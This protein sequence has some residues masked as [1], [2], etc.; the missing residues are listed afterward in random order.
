[1]HP[2]EIPLCRAVDQLIELAIAEDIGHGDITT[3][4]LGLGLA[5]GQARIVANEPLVIAG[6]DAVRRVYEKLGCNISFQARVEEG[7]W[8]A[9]QGVVAEL[10]SDMQSLLLG[11]RI[12]L[13]FLQRISG[14]ATHVRTYV[15][16]LPESAI[17]LTDTRKTVP[18]WRALE[19]YAVRVGGACNHR[20]GLYDGV[21]IK[22]NHIAACGGIASAV[23][24]VRSRVSHLIRIEV[25]TENLQQVEAALAEG[26]D[27]IMLD[28]MTPEMIAEAV[29]IIGGKAAV[30]V[31]GRVDREQ[32]ERLSS[33][34]VD[35]ISSGA[36]THA[37]RFVDLSMCMASLKQGA[38][39]T[40]P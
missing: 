23:Q 7:A 39:G 20:M 24:R 17:R 28:N 26:A 10:K 35:V 16:T 33:L 18:G 38:P 4:P 6:L 27:V 11:E 30:E 19:K 21:L 22:D 29:E 34:G 14:I 15:D 36:L 12:A 40:G 31:S 8:V 5:A 9:P 3:E 32:L 25:E 37:A 2:F 13:N 1:M